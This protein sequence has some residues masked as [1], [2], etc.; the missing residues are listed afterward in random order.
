MFLSLEAIG[1]RTVTGLFEDCPG[2]TEI[3]VVS[4][5]SQQEFHMILVER[6]V[7]VQIA[8]NFVGE[9]LNSLL[10]CIES[11]YFRRKVALFPHRKIHEFYPRMIREV[12]P[13][14]G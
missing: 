7:S 10:S 12:R 11:L 5:L 4:E 3:G 13:H 2:N 8:D 14:N 1:L 6:D 9:T